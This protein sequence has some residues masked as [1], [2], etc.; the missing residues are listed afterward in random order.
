MSVTQYVRPVHRGQLF[1][2]NRFGV[3]NLLKSITRDIHKDDIRLFRE[4]DDVEKA[5][6]KQLVQAGPEMYT[7]QY[8]N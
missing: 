2:P 1:I 5:S 4:V 8:R 6:I 7:K 3:T